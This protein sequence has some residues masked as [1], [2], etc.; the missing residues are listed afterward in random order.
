MSG[1]HVALLRGINVGAA[2]RV[3]M[4]DLRALMEALGYTGV[5]TLLN[6]GN[7]VFN[8]SRTPTSDATRIEK[9]IEAELGVSSRVTV[10]TGAEVSGIVSK[11]PLDDVATNPSRLMIAV[12]TDPAD[13]TKLTPL[14]RED[15]SPESL[16]LGK[17]VAW[18]WCPDGVIDSA[19][20]KAIS[21]ALSDRVTTRNW[22]T[23]QKI[24][25]LIGAGGKGG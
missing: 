3:A 14:T 10:L 6:S 11:N 24:H 9:G 17:R 13:R 1:R 5:R 7:V 4:A 25:A 8:S 18:C 19:L 12:L 15:W 16:A 21:R 2:K 22:A 20:F 23:I